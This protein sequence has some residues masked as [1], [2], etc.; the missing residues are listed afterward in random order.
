MLKTNMALCLV[1]TTF[2]AVPALPQTTPAPATT[3]P[4]A[5]TTNSANITAAEFVTQAANSD[6]FEIQSS[7]LA[8][9][10]SQDNTIR[11]FAQHMVQDHTASSDKL[12]AAA[13]GQTVP[14][15]LDPEHAR[16]HEQLQQ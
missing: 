9:T 2:A 14:S 1:A 3:P 13:E 6:M 7:Q 16:M 8:L 5:A 12:K 4:S 15:A 11:T 10:K